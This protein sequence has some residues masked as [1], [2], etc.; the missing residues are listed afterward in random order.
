MAQDSIQGEITWNETLEAY[1]KSTGEKAFGLAWIHK[2]SEEIY[3]SKKSWIDLPV[4]VM[5]SVV[6]FC[7]VGS[8]SIFVGMPGVASLTLGVASLVVSVL[9]TVGSYYGFAKRAEGHRLASIQYARLY[10]FLSIELS[11]P[12]EQRMTAHDLLKYT[13]DSYE[14]LQEIAPLIP[15]SVQEDFHRKFDAIADIQKPEELNGLTRISVF[16]EEVQIVSPRPDRSSQ[17]PLLTSSQKNTPVLGH[18]S[19]S[20]PASGASSLKTDLEV[21]LPVVQPSATPP[22]EIQTV[23]P[24]AGNQ[25]S[26]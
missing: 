26:Q 8:T 18:L 12:R 1:F 10:R 3:S 2:K 23:V 17:T 21:S 4:I 19:L 7:S 11:L 6:G 25:E 20:V 15:Q 22:Q 24:V 13:K 5:S 9:N 14:R 16:Q